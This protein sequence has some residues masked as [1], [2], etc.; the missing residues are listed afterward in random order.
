MKKIWNA[1][2]ETFTKT[3]K[4]IKNP[5][6]FMMLFISLLG[7]IF[8]ILTMEILNIIVFTFFIF[9]L[10]EMLEKSDG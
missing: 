1:I 2:S 8:S 4:F 5:L 6:L 9:M 10:M 3:L 7:I